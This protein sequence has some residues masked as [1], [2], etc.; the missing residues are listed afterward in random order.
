MGHQEFAPHLN[1]LLITPLSPHTPCRG[2]GTAVVPFPTCPHPKGEGR[3][4]AAQCPA[5]S[6]PG[7][8]TRA[9]RQSR[10]WTSICQELGRWRGSR[11]GSVRAPFSPPAPSDAAPWQGCAF[12][13][14]VPAFHGMGIPA[15]ERCCNCH[16]CPPGPGMAQAATA[17][18]PGLTTLLPSSHIPALFASCLPP[19]PPSP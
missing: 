3:G 12:L 14:R 7:M 6:L 19:T 8:G 13:G 4:T 18:S 10:G 1:P 2:D 16:H 17:P 5:C 9:A 15:G 11:W